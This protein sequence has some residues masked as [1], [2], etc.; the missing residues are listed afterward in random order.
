MLFGR[1]WW[2]TANG[3]VS[4]PPRLPCPLPPYGSASVL[5]LDPV[6]GAGHTDAVGVPWHGC[7]IDGNEEGVTAR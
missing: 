4:T 3:P 7:E 1:P 6:P 5:N 2:G